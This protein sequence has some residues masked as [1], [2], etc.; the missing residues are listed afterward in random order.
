MVFIFLGKMHLPPPPQQLQSQPKITELPASFLPIFLEEMDCG[1]YQC[2]W[3]G[4]LPGT[5]MG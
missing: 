5:K 2:L 4:P 1:G 3:F